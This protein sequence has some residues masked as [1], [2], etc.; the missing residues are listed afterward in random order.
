MGGL[1]VELWHPHSPPPTLA[2]AYWNQVDVSW[3][4]NE[5][6]FLGKLRVLE[7]RLTDSDIWLLISLLPFC[8]WAKIPVSAAKLG[9]RIVAFSCS[10][11][12]SLCVVHWVGQ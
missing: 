4:G 2:P 8:L 7:E 9:V 3:K 10:D 12:S 5:R 1:H 6:F 11:A